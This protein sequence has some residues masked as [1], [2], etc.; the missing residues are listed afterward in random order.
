MRKVAILASEVPEI[1]PTIHQAIAEFDQILPDLRTMRNTL[2]HVDEYAL[3]TGRNKNV[4]RT[5][6]EVGSFS[7]EQLEWLGCTLKIQD[8]L[9]ASNLFFKAIVDDLELLQNR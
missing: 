9:K 6:L 7:E 1:K 3:D 5:A 2:E 8:A 4:S